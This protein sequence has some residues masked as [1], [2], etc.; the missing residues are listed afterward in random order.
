[1]TRQRQRQ[2]NCARAATTDR[3]W[4]TLSSATPP[5]PP[6]VPGSPETDMD[7]DMDM[8]GVSPTASPTPTRGISSLRFIRPFCGES[9]SSLTHHSISRF[10]KLPELLILINPLPSRPMQS[11]PTHCV[12]L[13]TY[14]YPLATNW[15]TSMTLGVRHVAVAI[16][17]IL[18]ALSGIILVSRDH[19]SFLLLHLSTTLGLL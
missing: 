3:F 10:A 14:F 18:H 2:A 13:R 15:S 7:M 11:P 1:V 12:P 5:P 8:A 17:A 19:P 6:I 16:T 9:A 4:L